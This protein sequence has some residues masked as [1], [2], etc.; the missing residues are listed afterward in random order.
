[1]DRQRFYSQSP[2]LGNVKHNVGLPHRRRALAIYLYPVFGEPFAEVLKLQYRSHETWTKHYSG[3]DSY[4]DLKRMNRAGI[5]L[6][7]W[8]LPK[9]LAQGLLRGITVLNVILVALLWWPWFGGTAEKVG[10][11]DRLLNPFRLGGFRPDCVW[12]VFSTFFIAISL[13][14][15]LFKARADGTA[16]V[17]VCLC[18]IEVLAFCSFV[19]RIVSSGLLDFG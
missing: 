14:S 9:T 1:V 16:R 5:S 17:N 12:L 3:T 11:V 15:F 18:L 13:F 2:V 10:E 7:D 19:Y 6:H 8:I 4:V